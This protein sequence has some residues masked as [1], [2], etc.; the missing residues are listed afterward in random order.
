MKENIKSFLQVFVFSGIILISTVTLAGYSDRVLVIVNED[1]ITESEFNY[2]LKTLLLDV[3]QSGKAP[4][5]GLNKQLLDSM[6]SDRLQIQEANRRGINISDA[7]LAAAIERFAQQQNISVQELVRNLEQVGQP[8][9]RFQQTVRES[10]TISRLTEYY[11]R[12]RVVVPDYEIEGFIAANKLGDDATE[13]QIAHIL[14]KDPE[15]N[16]ELAQRVREEITQGLSFQQAVLTY[17]EA[18]DAQEGGLIGWRNTAQLPEVFLEAVKN[19]QAGGVSDVVESPNGLH[20]LKLLDLKGD[21]TE[22]IQNQVRHIL[23]GSESKVAKSQAAKKLYKIR[24]RILA[25]ENFEQLARIFSDDAVSAANGGSL[26]WVSPGEMV[27]PFEEAFKQLPIG[28]VSQ[29]I[30][31]QYGVHILQVMD[32]RKKNVTDLMVRGRA[33]NLLRRQRADREFKQWVRELRE[34][35]YIEFISEPV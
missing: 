10:L 1:V 26:E 8:F 25:G 24:Q 34:Q 33:E 22:I 31:T 19:M 35:A 18:T 2:R 20:I 23:I 28:E 12:T 14:I 29:P 32:R 16:R 17:S 3:E 6:V 13:Y 27:P 21:R 15:Q 9:D 11:A 5:P 4:P 7:E 30:E